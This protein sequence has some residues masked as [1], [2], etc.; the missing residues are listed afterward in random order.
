M[1]ARGQR[2]D[3][4]VQVVTAGSGLGSLTGMN[5]LLTYEG[6]QPTQVEIPIRV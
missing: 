4:G 1:K 2:E 6:I 5:V 3:Q